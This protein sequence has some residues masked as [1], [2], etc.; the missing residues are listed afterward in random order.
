MKRGSF[1]VASF[2]L[3]NLWKKGTYLLLPPPPLR[4]EPEDPVDL[5][6]DEVVL[7]DVEVRAEDED[8][9]D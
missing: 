9:F 7:F 2:Y 1:T 4:I 6:V 8:P 5:D 3:Y